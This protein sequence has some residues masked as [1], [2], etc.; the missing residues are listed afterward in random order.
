MT[1]ILP[2]EDLLGEISESKTNYMPNMNNFSTT[3]QFFNLN[4]WGLLGPYALFL[5][6]S[7]KDPTGVS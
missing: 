7:P 1:S 6:Y 5:G 3:S 2:S 4:G